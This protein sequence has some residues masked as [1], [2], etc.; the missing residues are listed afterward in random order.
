MECAVAGDELGAV[1]DVNEHEDNCV[2]CDDDGV[3]LSF[4]D[5]FFPMHLLKRMCQTKVKCGRSS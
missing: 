3:V 4:E 2:I 5:Q 1:G